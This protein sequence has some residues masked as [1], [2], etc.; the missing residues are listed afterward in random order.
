LGVLSHEDMYIW[1][2][3]SLFNILFGSTTL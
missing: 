3:Y 2:F 1:V